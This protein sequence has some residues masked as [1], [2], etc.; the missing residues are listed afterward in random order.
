MTMLLYELKSLLLIS[1]SLAYIQIRLTLA[2]MLFNFDF[3]LCEQSKN[4]ISHRT[5]LLWEKVPLMVRLTDR[6]V[7]A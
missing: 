1:N 4:W 7:Q 5:F 6:V 2:K 3:E